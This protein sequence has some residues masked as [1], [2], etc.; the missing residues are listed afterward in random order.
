[1]Y[2]SSGT[3]TCPLVQA[4]RARAIRRLS[5][6]LALCAALAATQAVPSR[7]A[8]NAGERHFRFR[9]LDRY[10]LAWSGRRAHRHRRHHHRRRAG[11]ARFHRVTRGRHRR[12][13]SGGFR[14]ITPDRGQYPSLSRVDWNG[15]F[16]PGCELIGS[17]PGA[18]DVNATNAD[19]VGGLTTIE[20]SIVGEGQC[21]AK[22]TDAASTTMVRSELARHATG[23][24]PEFTYEMLVYVPS[25]QS[26]PKGS[27]LTQTKEDGS[28]GGCYNGGWQIADN[29]GTTGGR[30]QLRTVFAC[31]TPQVNGQRNFDAGPLP[32]D[33]WFALKVHERFSNDPRVGF[34]QAWVD[35]DGTGPGGY[36]EVVPRTFLDNED[37]GGEH[38]RMRIGSYRQATSHT[39][40]L[41]IDGFRLKCWRRC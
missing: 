18:W 8:L 16:D 1:M 30:L 13:D 14:D 6:V 21:A 5:L 11:H 33:R 40:T 37:A 25:G 34:I 31:T 36:A 38:V 12:I 32:R 4:A 10:E 20:R 9:Q 39:T 3:G 23:P 22:F 29:T 28:A 27:T 24:D 7:A 26:F 41:Y 17:L 19:H 35:A 2:R 15:G